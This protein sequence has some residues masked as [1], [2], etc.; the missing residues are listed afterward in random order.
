MRERRKNMFI[1]DGW[2]DYR[3]LDTGGGMKLE[4]WAG[5]TL[6]RP[7]PQVIWEKQR[8]ELWKKAAASYAR[9]HT[10]CVHWDFFREL[11]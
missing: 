1:A 4:S 5:I 11:P 9:S 10:G 3:V 8:P 6:A 7:D 2:K